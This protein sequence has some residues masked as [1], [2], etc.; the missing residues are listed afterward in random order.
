MKIL[1]HSALLGIALLTMGFANFWLR[2]T[3]RSHT[4]YK[5][6]NNTDDECCGKCS[7]G[8]TANDCCCK[9]K[10]SEGA[11]ESKCCESG[12]GTDTSVA[13]KAAVVN[14][15]VIRLAARAVSVAACARKTKDWNLT[16]PR[17]TVQ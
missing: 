17:K 4:G 16:I 7:A 12:E 3:V 14:A 6:S 8:E 9:Q 5:Q 15:K 13:K 2:P 11:A 1:N 10:E